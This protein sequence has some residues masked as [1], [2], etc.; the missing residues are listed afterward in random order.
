VIVM[1]ELGERSHL[2]DPNRF[3]AC[4]VSRW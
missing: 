3:S 2:V 4:T 1:K